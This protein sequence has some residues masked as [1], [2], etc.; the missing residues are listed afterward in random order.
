MVS[1]TSAGSGHRLPE[2]FRAL[3]RGGL[4]APTPAGEQ[5]DRQRTGGYLHHIGSELV[6]HSDTVAR[7]SLGV[8]DKAPYVKMAR[9]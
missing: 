3:G 1:C 2:H 4:E 7:A 5:G 6:K 8:R 9:V